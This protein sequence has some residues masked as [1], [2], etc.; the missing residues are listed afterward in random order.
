MRKI[1]EV[2]RLRYELK[3]SYQQIERSCAIGVGKVYNYV[4]RFE[5]A[6]LSWPLST[7]WDQARLNTA[8]YPSPQARKQSA[9]QALPDFAAIHKELQSNKHV[10]LQLLW[11]EYPASQS[12]R[13]WLLALLRV[14]PALAQ[15]AR[16][17]AAPGTQGW[18]E[19]VRRLGRGNHP[20]L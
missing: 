16:R 18:R 5:A 20:C 1:K 12:G 15:E 19:N 13:L 11:D 7:E 10:T 17:S 2:L 4:K 8:L 3:L 14:V 6:G 9:P